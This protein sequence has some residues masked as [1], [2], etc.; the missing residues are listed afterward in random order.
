[1]KGGTRGTGQPALTS[2]TI[3]K[4]RSSP[5]RITRSQKSHQVAPDGKRRVKHRLGWSSRNSSSS[6]RPVPR[7]TKR[8]VNQMTNR[9]M[10]GKPVLPMTMRNDKSSRGKTAV[11]NE[12]MLSGVRVKPRSVKAEFAVKK[13]HQ[14]QNKKTT[15]TTRPKTTQKKNHNTRQTTP[16]AQK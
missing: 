12:F 6:D 4:I 8:E 9:C 7:G 10:T 14:I 2:R 16:K 3:K 15:K 13:P 1:M 11:L 5:L